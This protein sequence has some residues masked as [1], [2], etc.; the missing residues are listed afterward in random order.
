MTQYQ[1]ATLAV[2]QGIETD[3]QHG[4]IV[5]PIYLSTNYSFDGHTN[6]RE[7]D[8]SRSGNP[9]RCILGEAIAKLEQGVTGVVTCTGMAAIT[10]VTSLL[11]PDDLLVVPHDCYGGSYRLFTN[12]A[13]KGQ[14]KLL[15]VDQTDAQALGNAIAQNPKMVWLET[16]SNPLLRVVDINAISI[17][18][19]EVGALV[20]VDNTFLSPIL[21]QPL[22]L[23][24][25]IVIHSTTKYINGHSDVV[26]GAVVAKDAEVGELLH[27]WS[28]TLGLTG[29]AFDSY[30][31][32]RGLRTLAVRIR[33][34][35]R[36]A[37]KIV[38]LL[39]ASDVVAKVYY[40]G[41]KD[42]PGHEIAAKQQQGFGAMLSFELT[43]GEAEVVAFLQALSLFSIAE[44]LGGVESLVAVPATMTHRAMDPQARQQAGIKDTLLRLSVG[45]EDADDLLVD[46][47]AGLAAV[48]AIK[49][50]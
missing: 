10:L 44:S 16:P 42:H 35:Q 43:G 30:L 20:A 13:K 9:T 17:A 38:E 29:S 4:A 47:Q 48:T 7:F 33:E 46:I 25:D 12:L 45:I 26:G 8:Y 22:L 6:P 41:L 24:A 3:T 14:F 34:H 32:L 40:P 49:S 1:S 11:G 19:H 31:T 2:R 23:G 28:N 37:Q 36:N 21:Q 15:V 39:N 27:W 5:P 50:A 18:C